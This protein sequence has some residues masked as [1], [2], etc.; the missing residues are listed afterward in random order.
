[1]NK[2]KLVVVIVAVVIA[3]SFNAYSWDAEKCT[4]HTLVELAAPKFSQSGLIDAECKEVFGELEVFYIR[5]VPIDPSVEYSLTQNITFL[6]SPGSPPIFLDGTGSDGMPSKIK[7]GAEGSGFTLDGGVAVTGFEFKSFGTYSILI[8]SGAALNIIGGNKFTDAIG[9]ITATGTHTYIYNNEF[10]DVQFAANS[11]NDFYY[12]VKFIRNKIVPTTGEGLLLANGANAGMVTPGNNVFSIYTG[13]GN[14][15]TFKFKAVVSPETDMIQIYSIDSVNNALSYWFMCDA[16]PL[17][18][19]KDIEAM[20]WEDVKDLTGV[21]LENLERAWFAKKHKFFVFNP[22]AKPTLGAAVSKEFKCSSS[23]D[24]EKANLEWAVS[25]LKDAKFRAIATS[26]LA[27]S[28]M[29]SAEFAVKLDDLDEDGVLNDADNCPYISNIHQ[30]NSDGDQYGDVCEP[31]SDGDTVIDDK[32]NCKMVVNPSQ[33]DADKDG[34]GDACDPDYVPPEGDMDADG[35]KNSADNCLEVS[36]A[37]QK[38]MDKDGIGDACDGDVDND[39]AVGDK[40]SCPLVANSGKDEDKDGIDDVCDPE[41][42]KSDLFGEIQK[43]EEKID[44]NE[45]KKDDAGSPPGPTGTG[46]KGGGC[47]LIRR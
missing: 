16:S 2:I 14:I 4:A 36:N 31:D 34:L 45:D 24:F 3:A 44:Q 20:M 8:W 12:D 28:S 38:D 41:I 42:K 27:G 7:S 5:F 13:D 32:D 21:T 30:D 6:S 35:V 19:V 23:F 47:S 26:D 15:F 37:D 9:G 11:G 1:M 17:G 10:K 40:D 18:V 29:F 33:E 39:G 46:S 25:I 22:T 43:E